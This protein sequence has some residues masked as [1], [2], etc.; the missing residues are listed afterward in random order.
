MV[1][2]ETGRAISLVT[3]GKTGGGGVVV[4]VVGAGV[5]ED[6]RVKGLRVG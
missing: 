5:E 3:A 4:G 1:E 6:G 2:L